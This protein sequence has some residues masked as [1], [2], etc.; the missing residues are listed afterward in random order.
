MPKFEVTYSKL[1]KYAEE[2]GGYDLEELD[3]ELILSFVPA[4]PEAL[5]KGWEGESPPRVIMHGRIIKDKI[6]F[7]LVQVE[8]DNEL[9][10]KDLDLA[11]FTY[12]S[13]LHYIEDNY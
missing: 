3:N 1:K 9:I 11:E 13:W 4:F 7:E 12:R 5:E 2:Q 10:T 8:K 6:T